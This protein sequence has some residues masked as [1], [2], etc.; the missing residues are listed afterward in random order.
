ML[1]CLHAFITCYGRLQ[2]GEWV[3]TVSGKGNLP[4]PQE[5]VSLSSP[6]GA[7]TT[8]IIPFRNPLDTAVSVDVQLTG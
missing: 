6:A 5:P 1:F 4:E 8:V 2:F 7:N 3:F